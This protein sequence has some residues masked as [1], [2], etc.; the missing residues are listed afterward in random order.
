M[1]A[2]AWAG[3]IS[4]NWKGEMATPD[5]NTMVLTY[6]FKQDGG[7]LTGSLMTQGQTWDL[8]NGKV[9]GNK[10]SFA[11]H[12][13]INGG[14]NFAMQGTANGDEITLTTR[15][16]GADHDFPPMTLKREK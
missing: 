14:M 12:V 15:D 16:E 6:T 4:G 9:E 5:G 1:A 3:D 2:A 8:A 11:I 13:D 7:K 10:L